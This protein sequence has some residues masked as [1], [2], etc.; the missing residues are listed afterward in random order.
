[1]PGWDQLPIQPEHIQILYY[2]DIYAKRTIIDY[3]LLIV[4]YLFSQ[5]PNSARGQLY[6]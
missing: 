1:M 2:E 4:Q 6:V 5:S 3:W